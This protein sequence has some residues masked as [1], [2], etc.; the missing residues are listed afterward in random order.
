MGVIINLK[1]SPILREFIIAWYGTDTI[2][3]G[4][5]SSL[6]KKIKYHLELPPADYH[7][8]QP[9]CFIRIELV[10]YFWELNSK[11]K[12]THTDF[13]NYLSEYSI[14]IINDDLQEWFKNIFR[15]FV[16]GFLVAHK[17]KTGS[18]K[19]A[20]YAFCDMYNLTM[21]NINYEMLKKDWDRSK[22]KSIL[23]NDRKFM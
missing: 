22:Q 14:T 21:D 1:V 12:C 2:K 6:S 15:N 10:N 5:K 17:M 11:R 23:W 13:R 16:A 3:A 20:F 4:K 19:K 18:Q 8:S 9:D 7:F